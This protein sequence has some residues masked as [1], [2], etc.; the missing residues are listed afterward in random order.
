MDRTFSGSDKVGEIVAVYPG[1]SNLFKANSIDFC[2]GGNRTLESVLRKQGIEEGGFLAE[3]NESYEAAGKRA[4][5]EVDWLSEPSTELIEHVVST[6]HAYIQKELPLLSEFTTKVL[7]VHG[8]EQGAVL[9]GLHRLFHTMKLEL[10]QHLISEEEQIFPLIRQYEREPSE[11]LRAQ[12]A[13][14]IEQLESEH[15]GV[16]EL[17]KQ[18]RA[19]TQ[20]YTLPE[21]AC[22]TYTLTY[23]KLELLEE[24]LFRHIHLENH[25]LFPRYVQSA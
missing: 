8:Q 11:E 14:V 3:L 1:A 19:I 7:R 10:E 17:L 15:S 2:C 5:Q 24:D 18:M 12:I 6:H 20:N 4:G 23:Q 9:S 16:G 25:I 22:R 13:S 21:G